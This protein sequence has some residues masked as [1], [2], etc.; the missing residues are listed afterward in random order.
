MRDIF[1]LQMRYYLAVRD[2]DIF[3]VGECGGKY[4]TYKSS[5][6]AVRGISLAVK[7]ISQALLISQIRE[8]LYRFSLSDLS[9]K[10]N[11][12]RGSRLQKVSKSVKN[13]GGNSKRYIL[14]LV[15][16]FF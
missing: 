12:P 7:Q 6:R 11:F 4:A 1:A 2:S 5:R 16:F 3:A 14:L 15:E 13:G 8:D 10:L 9:D